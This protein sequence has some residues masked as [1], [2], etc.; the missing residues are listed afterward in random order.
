MEN[1]SLMTN[2]MIEQIKQ[3][4]MQARANVAQTV[5]N[6]LIVAYWNKTY[7]I[8][9]TLSVKLSQSNQCVMLLI[10]EDDKRSFYEKLYL[11]KWTDQKRI[12]HMW[13]VWY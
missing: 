7:Q 5:N 3:V 8:Q 4:M 12:Q 10:T 9:Q 13:I 2:E 6:E 1:Y 11:R